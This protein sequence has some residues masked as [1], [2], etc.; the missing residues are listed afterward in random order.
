MDFAINKK[1]TKFFYKYL[2]LL[3]Q[4]GMEQ[5]I[6]LQSSKIFCLLNAT[7]KIF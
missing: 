2:L 5:T 6:Y 1:K 3:F 4:N 7:T